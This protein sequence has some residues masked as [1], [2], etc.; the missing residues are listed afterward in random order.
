MSRQWKQNPA[1]GEL[2]KIQV[3]DRI[4]LHVDDAFAY[5]VRADVVTIKGENIQAKLVDIF[6]RETDGGQ[7][8]GGDIRELEGQAVHCTLANVFDV[9][10]R[11]DQD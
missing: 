10:K 8:T 4:I 7:I 1:S 6:T 9:L 5:N 3:G 11:D 2:R